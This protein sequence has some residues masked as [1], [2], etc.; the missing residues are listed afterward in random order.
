[1][2]KVRMPENGLV[3]RIIIHAQSLHAPQAQNTTGKSEVGSAAANLLTRKSTCNALFLYPIKPDI[4]IGKSSYTFV[5]RDMALVKRGI[6][7]RD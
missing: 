7:C 1:M 6:V 4:Y 3:Y 5:S 2:N